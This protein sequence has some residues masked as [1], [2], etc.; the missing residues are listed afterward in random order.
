[1]KPYRLANGHAIPMKLRKRFRWTLFRF[2]STDRTM[3]KTQQA[4]LRR[5]LPPIKLDV[6]TRWVN[7]TFRYGDQ[8]VTSPAA[9]V[10]DEPR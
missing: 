2:R 4:V 6:P 3:C 9:G 8:L 10:P 5:R 1:M 7:Y